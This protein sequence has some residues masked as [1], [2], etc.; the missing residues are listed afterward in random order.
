MFGRENG[1]MPVKG[2][3]RQFNIVKAHNLK[4]AGRKSGRFTWCSLRQWFTPREIKKV[5]ICGN[6]YVN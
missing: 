1:E 6:I 3:N 2:Y 4:T 5:T